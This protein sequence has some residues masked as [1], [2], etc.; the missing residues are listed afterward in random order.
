MKLKFISVIT[1]AM[2]LAACSSNDQKEQDTNPTNVP[3]CVFADGSNKAAPDWVCGAPITGYPLT[4]VGYSNKSGAG[5]TFMIDI[6]STAA[7]V[8]LA[9][10]L[11][12]NIQNMVKQY[13]E[14]T[15]SADAETVDR[16]NSVVT[17]QVTNQKLIGSRVVRQ[18]MTPSGGFVVAVGLD[19]KK[20]EGIAAD[21]LRSSMKNEAALYQKVESGKGFKEL[22]DEIAKQK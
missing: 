10:T 20:T 9:Q 4:A 5:P 7:R 2:L 16:V 13:A 8:E 21:I 14:T 18:M 11:N 15:G 6:A 3:D 17:K 1:S 19:P 12:L 22:A